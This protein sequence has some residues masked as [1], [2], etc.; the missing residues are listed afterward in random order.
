V[1]V[2]A[3]TLPILIGALALSADIG[4]LY[5]NWHLLQN[6]ADLGAEAGASYLPSNPAQ[7]ISAADTYASNN[8]ILASEITS[9]TVSNDLKSLNI[10]LQR[11]IPYSFALLLGLV[12]GA[13]SAQATAQVQTI[14]TVT[15]ITPIG[16]DYR[17]SYTNGQ[18]VTL[19]QGQVG[20][21]NWGALAL[22]GTG[23]SNLSQNIESGYSGS[24]STGDLVTTET[25]LAVGPISTAFNFLITEGQSA[26]PGGTFASHTATD[27]RV[28]IV[29]MVNFSNI[30]GSSQVPVMGFAA[31]WL[32]GMDANG[33][34]ST[35]F[36]DQVAPRGGSPNPNSTNY[37]AYET[38]LVS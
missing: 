10:Q 35:Y 16:I 15:G 4:V 11:K 38:V 12:S 3:V 7:A 25:G 21:G 34:I 6:A 20:P 18:V 27:P 9:V 31:L 32:V 8:G 36:I 17:T 33:N 19:Q 26:D 30:N 24:I 22:G 2:L 23:A 1:V 37:G 29:P 13:V 28:L 14:G 5:F